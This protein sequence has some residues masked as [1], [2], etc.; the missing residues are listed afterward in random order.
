[1]FDL[2]FH[3]FRD[4]GRDFHRQFG[5]TERTLSRF[6]GRVAILPGLVR[7]AA[8]F[9]TV[10]GTLAATAAETASGTVATGTTVPAGGGGTGTADAC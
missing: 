4:R 9:V 7:I 2:R 8:H 1:M 5:D 10:P 3:D 6:L